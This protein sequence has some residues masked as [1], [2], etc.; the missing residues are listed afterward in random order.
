MCEAGGPFLRSSLR[1]EQSWFDQL[2]TVTPSNCFGNRWFCF[3][4]LG[5][6]GS[7]RAGAAGEGSHGLCWEEGEVGVAGEDVQRWARRRK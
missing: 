6:T 3:L 7:S 2:V 1:S 4:G 5:M